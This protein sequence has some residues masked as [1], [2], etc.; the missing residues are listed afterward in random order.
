MKLPVKII[1]VFAALLLGKGTATNLQAQNVDTLMLRFDEITEQLLYRNYDS[2]FIENYSDHISA[3]L[4]SESKINYFNA[5]DRD[6]KN[7][8]RYRPVGDLKVGIGLA[9]KFFSFD[10]TLGLG[11]GDKK[12][13]EESRFLDFQGRLFSS[14]QL[15]STTFQYY[16]GYRLSDVNGTPFDSDDPATRRG[17]VRTTNLML[18]YTYAFNYTKF[19]MK[20]PF[21][22]NER[23]KKSA[24]SVL[25]GVSFSLFNMNSDSSI[26]PLIIKESFNESVQLTSINVVNLG[27]QAGYMYT[28]VYKKN[29]FITLSLIPG[30]V[31]NYGDYAT[32]MRKKFPTHINLSLN[33][34]N[35]IGYNGEKFFTGFNFMFNNFLTTIDSHS[36]MQVGSG[37]L[38]AF[39]GYRFGII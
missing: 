17:D 31:L 30:M 3:K 32:D 16:Q 9:Y 1:V 23:Q 18:Q 15:I 6:S 33:S 39:I 7:T 38:S 8:L 21:V 28:Y 35:A 25:G 29:Y 37:K 36:K 27:V 14:K 5:K 12:G 19:S 20:A 11:L 13:L 4:V 34:M 2:N 10:L 26:V 24:G 22:F